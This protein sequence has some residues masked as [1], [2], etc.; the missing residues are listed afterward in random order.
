MAKAPRGK[1]EVKSA[2]PKKARGKLPRLTERQKKVL[3]GAAENPEATYRELG[4]KAGYPG[5]AKY[6][7][8]A[9]RRALESPN[10]HIRM[11]DAIHAAQGL[12]VADIV[13]ALRRGLLARTIKYFTFEGRVTDKRVDDDLAL[14]LAYLDRICK[15]G[16]YDPAAKTQITGADGKD[17]IPGDAGAAAS[18]A[19]ELALLRALP[20]EELLAVLG[21][22]KAAARPAGPQVPES[23]APQTPAAPAPAPA[24]PLA[25]QG[26]PPAA[27]VAQA[28]A[29]LADAPVPS[30]I[31]D[32]LNRHDN[33]PERKGAQP[34][35]PPSGGTADGPNG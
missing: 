11:R 27:D 19:A 8:E 21:L 1:Q 7:A 28:S 2:R 14:R 26:A 10:A 23:A 3:Q 20:K 24:G 29:P 9:A 6:K 33:C 17:L 13:A 12:G 25:P 32:E 16:D 30:A 4:E 5:S 31:E 35:A 22:G 15:L 34:P 18:L